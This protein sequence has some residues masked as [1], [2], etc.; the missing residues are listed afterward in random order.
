MLAGRNTHPE[1]V[2]PERLDNFFLYEGPER[3]A[4][5]IGTAHDLGN[6]PAKG[7]TLVP[8]ARARLEHWWQTGDRINHPVIISE[9]LGRD[10]FGHLPHAGAVMQYMA[11]CQLVLSVGRKFR[12]ITRH[13]RVIVHQPARGLD[14]QSG[15]SDRL[16]D[17]ESGEQRVRLHLSSR[18][19]VGD[20]GPDINDKVA[21]RV[22]SDLNAD[23]A[24][25]PDG[26]LHRI[27]KWLHEIRPDLTDT[28]VNPGFLRW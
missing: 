10:S 23:F 25:F 19:G 13:R 15:R 1:I 18:R 9:S 28:Y 24:A 4:F 16:D 27:S 20:A 8:I 5:R 7:Q 12:P 14:M 21:V 3:S 11:N 26:T 2:D 6:H 22:G 17:G